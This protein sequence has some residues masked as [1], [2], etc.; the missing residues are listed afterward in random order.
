MEKAKAIWIERGRP[1]GTATIM[2]ATEILKMLRI[3]NNVSSLTIDWLVKKIRSSK[4]AVM[5]AKINAP[6]VYPYMESW[7][8][9][10]LKRCCRGV[11]ASS[12]ESDP[13]PIKF[14]SVSI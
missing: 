13:I 1:S 3:V 11:W 4:K 5:E 2:M 9:M 7:S 6:A 8:A 12:A 10:L 14:P